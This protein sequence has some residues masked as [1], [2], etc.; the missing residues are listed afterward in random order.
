MVTHR[1]HLSRILS[2]RQLPSGGAGGKLT[3]EDWDRWK[4]W[5]GWA[6]KSFDPE[7]HELMFE[8]NEHNVLVGA[9]DDWIAA[10]YLGV[11]IHQ[12]NGKAS[13]PLIIYIYV[14]VKDIIHQNADLSKRKRQEG[15]KKED[16]DSG[17]PNER[18]GKVSQRGQRDPSS[19]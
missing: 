15:S 19:F 18:P 16:T 9:K 17:G 8:C 6:F 10:C 13:G 7:R 5:I 4:E 2:I 12:H 1:G 11:A 14:R 3:D